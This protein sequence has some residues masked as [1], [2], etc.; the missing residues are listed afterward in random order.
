MSHMATRGIWAVMLVWVLA[1]SVLAAPPSGSAAGTPKS[2]GKSTG[3]STGQSTAATPRKPVADQGTVSKPQPGK[4]AAASDQSQSTSASTAAKPAG[5]A[6]KAPA[7]NRPTAEKAAE[8]ADDEEDGDD[9]GEN[10]EDEDEDVAA[11]PPQP[12]TAEWYL[13]EVLKLRLIT[14]E[15]EAG[16]PSQDPKFLERQKKIVELATKSMALTHKDPER[17][18]QF[19]VSAR[20]LLDARLQLAMTG[21]EDEVELLYE[22][23]RA[24][25][26][27]DPASHAA[28]HGA[29]TLVNLAY[30]HALHEQ[31]AD[32]AATWRAEFAQ[33][34]SHYLQTFPREE[35]RSVPLAYTA[36]RLCEQH[37]QLAEAREC[38]AQI[39]RL[40]PDSLH[41]SEAERILR[42]FDLVGNPPPVAGPTLD[43]E[44]LQLDDLLGKPVLLVFWSSE[45]ESCAKE[46]PRLLPAIR[47][48]QQAG[49]QVVGMTLD[50]NRKAV[51]A[52]VAKHKLDWIQLHFTD[53]EHQGWKNPVTTHFGVLEVPAFW[54]ID[55]NGNAVSTTATVAS[56]KQ[57]L[58]SLT[59]ASGLTRTKSD[60]DEQ[61]VPAGATRE[62]TTSAP[63]ASGPASAK[64]SADKPTEPDLP[65]SAPAGSKKPA[66]PRPSSR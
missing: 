24:F 35:P 48:A 14:P 40:T 57:E 56:F 16:E 66:N 11:S 59:E 60:G 25:V 4:S 33:L 3:Q 49:V 19:E 9:D 61:V 50:T 58:R 26:K 36:G 51:Q 6:A 17:K 22:N 32:K 53:A 29:N 42:R 34:A 65:R 52:F 30:H 8:P 15:N 44:M 10:P 64:T 54:L 37:G 46:I 5:V 20:Y 2:G 31:A 63:A 45:A 62:R 38:Y 13:A 39:V 47:Q 28:A 12:G 27:R 18:Q 23:A 1:E 55:A 7:K 43:G 21:N 41:G